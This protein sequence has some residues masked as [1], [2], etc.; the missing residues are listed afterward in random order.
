MERQAGA[1]LKGS[2]RGARG[3]GCGSRG[4]GRV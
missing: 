2:M 3:D 1:T 4:Q